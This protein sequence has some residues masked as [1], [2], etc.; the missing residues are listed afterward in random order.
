MK[1]KNYNA[2]LM[3]IVLGITGCTT[4]NP[5]D[6]SFDLSEEFTEDVTISFFGWGSKEEQSNFQKLCN[7]FMKQE[8]HIN[9]AYSATDSSTYMNTLKNRANSL[10]DVFYMPDYAFMEW[11]DSNRLLAI[12]DYMSDEEL[13]SMWEMSTQMYRYDAETYS[14]NKG[15]LYGL[16]KDLGPYTLVYNKTL[17]RECLKAN[18]NYVD[19]ET[20]IISGN[21]PMS[22]KE[23]T[24]YLTKANTHSSNGVYPIG[25]YELMSAVYSNNANFFDES[26][27]KEQISSDNFIEAVQFIA[28]LTLNGLAPTANEQSEQNSF[29]RFI[30][31]KCIFTFMGPW[32]MATFW[33]D[34][35]FEFDICPV[36][37]GPAEGAKSTTWVGS[38]AYCINAK[39][40]Q[41]KA[42]VKFAKFLSCSLK[43]SE[44]NYLLGQAVPNVISYAKEQFVKGVGYDE[45]QAS[46][47]KNRQLFVDIIEGTSKIQGKQRAKYFLYD[48]TC[49]DD[50]ESNLSSVYTGSKTAREFLEA[51]ASTFQ[52]GLD[53]SN[54]NLN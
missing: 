43:S 7:E 4:N 3:T 6:E 12:D 17:L 20:S 19:D 49:Y 30:T 35:P 47:P 15:K 27:K 26:V 38:V 22:W 29:Q 9:V 48:N 18:G 10:P 16:P 24:D 1:S 53:D 5:S 28:D 32:D 52:H 54:D 33:K 21:N 31:E 46:A 8:P 25:Y 51:Y 40:T 39:S 44:M 14:L 42:A 36:P 13:S 11:A 34:V 23:F 41:K 2:L 45:K 37:Y 50:L